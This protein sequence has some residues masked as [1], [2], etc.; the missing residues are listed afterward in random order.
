M[1]VRIKICGLTEEKTAYLAAQAGADAIGLVFAPS[2]RQIEPEL[3]RRIREGLPPFVAAVGVMMDPDLEEALELAESCGLDAIQ[4]HG[5]ES[6]EFCARLAEK[7]R[8]RIIK[9]FA[10]SREGEKGEELQR[11]IEA[12]RP[13]VHAFLF[14][15]AVGKSCGGTGRTFNWQVLSRLRIGKPWLLAGGL[16]A[17]NVG[18]ALRVARPWGVDV[19]SGVESA[20][21]IKDIMRIEAFIRAVRRYENEINRL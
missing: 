20:P 16:D 19:S 1:R 15:T 3:A 4:L 17:T 13:V 11:K 9:T 2:R 18:E 12:Y 7:S 6:P 5:N 14:D 8:C 10:V 21:G